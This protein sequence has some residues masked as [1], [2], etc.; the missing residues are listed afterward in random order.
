MPVIERVT[1]TLPDDLVRDIDRR[2]KNRSKFVAEAVRRELDR[3][4]REELRRSLQNP[5]PE[6]AELADQGLE[7]WSRS[8]PEEDVE[9]LLDSRAGRAVRWIPGEGWVKDRG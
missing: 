4:R 9:A 6:S 7:D 8:L 1:V 5:H 2:E 3:R